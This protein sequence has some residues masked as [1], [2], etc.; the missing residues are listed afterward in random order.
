MG[1]SSPHSTSAYADLDARLTGSGLMIYGALH[2]CPAPAPDPGPCG[3]TLVLLG[4]DASF[5]PLFKA[6]PEARDGSPDPI[7]RWSLRVIGGLAAE[8]GAQVHYPFT[9]PPYAPFVAWALASGRAFT[10]PSQMLVHDALGLLISYRGALHFAD[11]FDIP[12]SPLAR[13]PCETCPERPCL[14]ACPAHALVDGGPYRVAACHDHLD[15]PEGSACMDRGCLAR[16]AC[17]LSAGAGRR[18]EQTAHHMR[19]FHRR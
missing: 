15:R 19:Y 11:V 10:S 14:A 3:G 13:S 2:P 12:P 16:R 6:A 4:T 17:P 8:W 7:D 18:P 1:L 9:G 5:W